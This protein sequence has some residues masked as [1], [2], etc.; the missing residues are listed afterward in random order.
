MKRNSVFPKPAALLIGMAGLVPFSILIVHAQT[1]PCPQELPALTL[2]ANPASVQ[3]NVPTTVRFR[4]EGVGNRKVQSVRVLQGQGSQK[5]PV[6]M[7]QKAFLTQRFFS[8]EA[9]ITATMAGV[10]S[11]QAEV[12]QRFEPE[13]VIGTAPPIRTD[14]A[15]VVTT[16]AYTP[17]APAFRRSK[18]DAPARAAVDRA[19]RMVAPVER[20]VVT[21]GHMAGESRLV[22]PPPRPANASTCMARSNTIRVAVTAPPPPAPPPEPEEERPPPRP[23]IPEPEPEPEPPSMPQ[24]VLETVS[25]NGVSLRYPAGWQVNQGVIAEG[26]PLAL[27]NF[28]SRYL[29]GGIAPKGGAEIDV[30]FTAKPRT[31]AQQA[32]AQD[33]PDAKFFNTRQLVVD[34]SAGN[35]AWYHDAFGPGLVTTNAV[36]YVPRGRFLYKFFLTFHAKDPSERLFAA[37]FRQMLR[38]VQFKEPR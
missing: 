23:P 17:A 7:T 22:A 11:A 14:T 12:L 21:P 27:N 16:V 31:T 25:A 8:G 4:L 3:L 15:P 29:P 32:L 10:I 26:G 24:P 20:P 9:V 37:Q 35:E 18:V 13:P 28:N 30:T 19:A 36:V 38:T 34:G 5:N 33:L 1:R 2:S 6:P